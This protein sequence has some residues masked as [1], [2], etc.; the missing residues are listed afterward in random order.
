MLD[1]LL[2]E[3]EPELRDSLGEAL[4]EEGHE[5]ELV[6]DGKAALDR[7]AAR[8]FHLVVSD[9]RLPEVDGMTLLQRVRSEFP[10]TEVL[11][12]TAYGSL[13]DAARA[14]RDDAVQYLTKPF[15][16][17]ELVSVV[18]QVDERRRVRIR[19]KAP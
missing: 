7:L 4:R 8:P 3:D 9:V 13:G 10:S 17:D 16:L 11:L 5:V 18:D 19:Q 12:M 6:G 1:I 2:V 14:V 15:D